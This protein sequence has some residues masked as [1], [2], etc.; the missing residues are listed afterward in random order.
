[1]AAETPLTPGT[2]VNKE[3]DEMT[4]QSILQI[5]LT[6]G[7]ALLLTTPSAMADYEVAD[8][9]A[10][11]TFVDALARGP[12]DI[13]KPELGLA[14]WGFEEYVLGE[15]DADGNTVLSLGDG[16]FV[17]VGFDEPIGDGPGSDFA[18]FENG[19][20]SPDGFFAELAF[21]EVSSNGVDFVRFDAFTSNPTP[22]PGGGVVDPT[23]YVN[24]AGT[25]PVGY[26]TGFDLAE[27][28]PHPFVQAGFLDLQDVNFVRLVDV[29]GNGDT[30]DADFAPIYDPYATPFSTSG[31]DLDGVGVLN[32]PEPGGSLALIAGLLSLVALARRRNRP[33]IARRVPALAIAVGLV[34]AAPLAAQATYTVDF[35][36]LGLFAESYWN[37][38]DLSGG[39]QS[40]PV[41]FQ[42]TNIPAWSYWYGFAAS[43]VTDNV[44]PGYVNQYSA[45]AGSGAGGSASYGL[46]FDD[47][48]ED[49]HMLLPAADVIDG[50]W[51]TNTTYAAL[52]MQEGDDFAK[53]FGGASGDDPDFF[54]L[55]IN[56]YDAAGTLTGSVDFSLADFT[57]ADNALDYIVDSWTWVDLSSLGAVK[58]LGFVLSSSDASGGFLNTPGF[59]AIDG[60]QVVPEP[61]SAVLLGIGLAGLALR[62]R[63]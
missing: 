16:G 55:T 9:T 7:L 60:V 15:A 25:E 4:M 17:T 30:F 26:G 51:I 5:A 33:D 11:A 42:N 32:V 28:F 1:L 29:I 14:A 18:V 36:D 22:I 39:F 56:G 57:F 37:G 53:K 3:D 38:A 50:A 62:R 20:W 8:M 27:L 40:G 59:F 23:D 47:P 54:I 21:V 41:T 31:F 43:T 6:A 34:T 63:R 61:A 49:P 52:S 58:E 19:F 48:L 44:T 12:M 13:A 10:W 24:L 45:I 46:F 2:G 35:E